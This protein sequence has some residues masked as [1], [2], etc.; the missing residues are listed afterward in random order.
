[1]LM[2]GAYAGFGLPYSPFID[3]LPSW[4]V[5]VF[6]GYLQWFLVVPAILQNHLQG[7]RGI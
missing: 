4:M 6:F 3:L 1:M 5:M 7:R 2:F